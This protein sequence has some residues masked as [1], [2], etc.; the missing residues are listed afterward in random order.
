MET[1]TDKER[2]KELEAERDKLYYALLTIRE[3]ANQG[4]HLS[5]DLIVTAEDYCKDIINEVD[6]IKVPP[7]YKLAKEI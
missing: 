1:K 5:D 6:K 4:V 7:Q 2:I 3:L